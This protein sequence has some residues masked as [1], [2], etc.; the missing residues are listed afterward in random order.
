MPVDAVKVVTDLYVIEYNGDLWK[1]S[2][3]AYTALSE[4]EAGNDVIV[5]PNPVTTTTQF[6][7]NAHAFGLA[8]L[9]IN[10]VQGRLMLSQQNIKVQSGKNKI[11]IDLSNL[12]SG[13]YFYHLTLNGFTCKG[14]IS[15]I[16]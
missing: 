6:E 7:F 8:K 9:D 13:M 15:K 3:P 10:D 12:K 16:R 4:N 1:I 14:K 11:N 2:F 5:Y